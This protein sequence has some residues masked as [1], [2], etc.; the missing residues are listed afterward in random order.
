MRVEHFV[1]A[2]VIA[3]LRDVAP[4]GAISKAR[5]NKGRVGPPTTPHW[6]FR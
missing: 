4:E 6:Q 5:G 2:T 3:Q 1:L